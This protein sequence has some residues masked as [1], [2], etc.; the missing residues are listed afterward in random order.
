MG[1]GMSESIMSAPEVIAHAELDQAI[2]PEDRRVPKRTIRCRHCSRLNQVKVATAV[3]EP[4][5]HHCGACDGS[6]FLDPN[7]AYEG[8]SARAYQHSLDR[9]SVAAL[10]AVPGLPQMMRWLLQSV[11]DRGAQ[12]M[13]MSDA[14]RCSDDQF[15]ELIAL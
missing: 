9:R 12:L 13:F 1:T 8:I 5:R 4:D 14:I 2:W 7:E 6:L 15:P 3:I 10:R 11:G